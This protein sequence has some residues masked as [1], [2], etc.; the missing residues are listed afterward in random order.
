ML[1]EHSRKCSRWIENCVKGEQVWK[2]RRWFEWEVQWGWKSIMLCT[3]SLGWQVKARLRG[4]WNT[5]WVLNLMSAI[6]CPCW[7]KERE[8]VLVYSEF[9]YVLYLYYSCLIYYTV[10]HLIFTVIQGSSQ[11]LP[12]SSLLKIY[13]LQW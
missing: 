13:K 8:L 2:R 11:L 3:K 5:L 1:R 4:A 9:S 12:S 7:K 6:L 10:F